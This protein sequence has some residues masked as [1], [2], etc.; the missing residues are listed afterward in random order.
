MA[1]D[2]S[3]AD[4][5][6]F[7]DDDDILR[8]A[9]ELPRATAMMDA[10][11]YHLALVP[12]LYRHNDSGAVTCQH[13]RA[14]IAR[15][16]RVRWQGVYHEKLTSQDS[17][18]TVALDKPVAIDLCENRDPVNK[19]PLRGLKITMHAYLVEARRPE[20]ASADTVYRLA[21]E[22]AQTM[23]DL[24]MQLL[25]SYVQRADIRAYSR[26]TAYLC[27][28]RIHESRDDFASATKA[29]DDALTAFPRYPEAALGL[30]RTAFLQGRF[31]DAVQWSKQGFHLSRL[32]SARLLFHNPLEREGRS[33]IFYALALAN[34]GH[35]DE[36]QTVWEQGRELMPTEFAGLKNLLDIKRQK[37]A[38]ATP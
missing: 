11:N 37:A 32:P 13:L 9:D 19:V 27:M 5:I 14:S 15:R 1:L 4:H 3:S 33:R 29:Y 23:P 6:T 35:H 12:Y 20:G 7:L 36:A 10:E 31:D 25:S 16:E 17:E 2:A 22:A 21:M 8:D 18:R 24:A 30:A 28:G 34:T 26:A 38:G